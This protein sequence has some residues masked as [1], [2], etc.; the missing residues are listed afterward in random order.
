MINMGWAELRGIRTN[1]WKYIRAPKPELYDLV[2]DPAEASNVL[3][4]HLIEA[5]ELETKLKAITGSGVT[6]NPEQVETSVLDQRTM[7][8]LK[9]LGYLSG[10]SQRQYTLTG[11]GIDPKDRIEILKSLYLAASPG[12]TLPFSRRIVMLRQAVLEDPAN[13]SVYYYLGGLYETAGRHRDAMK[14]YQDAISQGVRT[15][16]LYSR[17]GRLYLQEGKKNEAIASYKRAALLN[18]SDCE[19]LNDLGM[20]YLEIGRTVDAERV[21]KWTLK[22]GAEYAP[23]YN[24]LGLASIQKHDLSSA[25]GYFEK[26]VQL[27]PDLLEAQLNLGRIYKMTGANERARACFEAF[28]A[29]ASRA[30]YGDIIPKIKEELALMQ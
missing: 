24:G 28:L 21:F 20:S 15:A 26:A 9:S 10:S 25:R 8:Q 22:T 23:A 18:P 3:G 1:R 27:A 5:Q 2:H 19:S 12:S 11:T 14:L 13:P 4:N 7:E 6:Q 17:I 29:R 16:W 30:E